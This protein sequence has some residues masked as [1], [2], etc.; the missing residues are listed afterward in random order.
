VELFGE[1]IMSRFALSLILAM[2]AVGSGGIAPA[3]AWEYP[4]TDTYEGYGMSVSCG[5]GNPVVIRVVINKQGLTTDSLAQTVSFT[6]VPATGNEAFWVGGTEMVGGNF[7]GV[8]PSVSTSALELC[9][10]IQQGSVE[11]LTQIFE[12]TPPSAKVGDA[13]QMRKMS[14]N[15]TAVIPLGIEMQIPGP[16]YVPVKQV[17]DGGRWKFK[18]S[19]TG[20][21]DGP[22]SWVS[23]ITRSHTVSSVPVPTLPWIGLLALSGFLGLFGSHKLR[24]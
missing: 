11:E 17:G 23:S 18:I 1:Q 14:L 6:V 4:E 5:G 24:K 22:F 19:V 2:A 21:V 9:D 8:R 16:G 10:G 7:G 3:S 15:F 20:E 13:I 12:Y